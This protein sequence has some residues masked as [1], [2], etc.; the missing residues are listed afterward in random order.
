[1]KVVIIGGGLAG[2][3]V[4]THLRRRNE[5]S[6]IVILEKNNEFAVSASALPYLLSGTISKP[7][8]IIGATVN[9][10]KQIFKIDVKLNHEVILN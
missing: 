4:A 5:N 7:E 3:S 9:Q 1:M 10:M 2:I 6:E 8:D